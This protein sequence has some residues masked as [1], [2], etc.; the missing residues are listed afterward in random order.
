MTIT[1]TINDAENLNK[2]TLVLTAEYLMNLA[3]N[4]TT[5]KVKCE[6]N[7]IPYVPA[8]NCEEVDRNPEMVLTEPAP[9]VASEVSSKFETLK[10]ENFDL[11]IDGKPWDELIHSRTKSKTADGR[12]KLKRGIEVKTAPLPPV[13]PFVAPPS[14]PV[15]PVVSLVAPVTPTLTFPAIMARITSAISTNSLSRDR[16]LGMIKEVGLVEIPQLAEP[17]NAALLP[18]INNLLDA[19]LNGGA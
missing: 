15:P 9:P 13:A 18:A 8:F 12:W 4:R 2:E 16:V 11:D 7:N 5:P 19:A 1:I 14:V 10:P 17:Q 6:L 3:E